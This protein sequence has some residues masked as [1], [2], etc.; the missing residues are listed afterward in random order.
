MWII[1]TPNKC[2]TNFI[3]RFWASTSTYLRID[4]LLLADVLL[5]FNSHIDE[6]LED[7][8]SELLLLSRNG[9]GLSAGKVEDR[10]RTSDRDIDMH[11]VVERGVRGEIS[12]ASNRLATFYNPQCPDH[13]TTKADN[14]ILLCTWMRKTSMA[15]QFNTYWKRS[16]SNFWQISMRTTYMA[17]AG[18]FDS[19]YK[20]KDSAGRI[21]LEGSNYRRSAGNSRW[22]TRG[23]PTRGRPWIPITPSR[24]PQRL[25]ISD[26]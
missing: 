16:S 1:N 12:M 8:S 14:W 7:R 25:S 9:L 21:Q 24:Y 5:T 6:A 20:W 26:R 11:L 23:L 17:L 19:Y 18:Q 4:V 2:G 22:Y 15:G 3:A 13:D 10:A